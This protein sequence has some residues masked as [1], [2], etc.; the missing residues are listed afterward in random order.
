MFMPWPVKRWLLRSVFGYEIDATAHIGFSF[1]MPDKLIMKANAK[2]DS[3][4]VCKGLALVQLDESSC[5][6]RFNWVTGFPIKLKEHFADVE[7]RNP[8][9]VIGKDSAITKGHI[10]DCTDAVIIGQ[11]TTIAGFQSQILTHSIDI[12]ESKQT[13]KPISIGNYC[14]VGT[15][16]VILGGAILPDYSVLGA[17]SLLN[18]AFSE[19]YHLYAGVPA[20][21][22]KEL[23]ESAKYFLRNQGLVQ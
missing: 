1:V 6:G 2:I 3:F 5:L 11:F 12:A 19:P 9:L 16:C 13:C 20:R 14:F 18:E 21:K 23:D 15:N 8:A 7:N 4:T 22:L 17:K 10:I